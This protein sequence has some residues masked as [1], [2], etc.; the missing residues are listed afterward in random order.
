MRNK[1]ARNNWKTVENTRR[2]KQKT[3]LAV[4]VLGLVIFLIIFGKG[5][6][7]VRS[8]FQPFSSDITNSYIWDGSYS[9]NLVIKNDFVS[10]LS[11]NPGENVI[12]VVKIPSETY[13][14]VP[15]GYG[16]WQ[17][18]SIYGLG[19]IKQG[20]LLLIKALSSFFGMPVDGFIEFEGKF[21]STSPLELVNSLR[22]NPLIIL[23]AMP[24]KTNLTP[25]ELMKLLLDLKSVRF[26]KVEDVDLSK[27]SL[28]D[29]TKLA[30][31]Q[32]AYIGDPVKIDSFSLTLAESKIISE[33]LS[34]AVFNTTNKGGVARQAARLITNIGGNVI[35]LSNANDYFKV[36]KI[37][38]RDQ[39]NSYTY[40]RL[41]QIFG[42]D[43]SDNPKCDK[44]PLEV[45][46]S[47]ADI[48]II[49]GEDFLT[50]F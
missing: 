38:S 18:R 17:V 37:V 12:S 28:L 46:E 23:Q 7:T 31:G 13:I 33:H 41:K 25:F 49:L 3:K 2:V 4:V 48:N 15:G 34:V 24:I 14:N 50:K 27:L 42:L 39:S 5:V 40:K 45:V 36:S 1:S 16:S 29:E 32:I 30:D 35:K 43:C 22:L 6:Q 44:I 21:A 19:G 20:S 8:L 11:F 47:R 10:L 9:I 26:D